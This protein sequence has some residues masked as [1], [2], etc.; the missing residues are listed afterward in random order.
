MSIASL[1]M[2]LSPLALGRNTAKKRLALAL[3]IS[4]NTSARSGGV[5]LPLVVA[6]VLGER[7]K[8]SVVLASSAMSGRCA[9]LAWRS[10]GPCLLAVAAPMDAGW[11]K[12]SLSRRRFCQ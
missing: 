8:V 6:T 3:R 12:V 11:A 2:L 10:C 9:A 4:E 1:M 7:H 5:A